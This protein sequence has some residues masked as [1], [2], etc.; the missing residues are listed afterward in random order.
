MLMGYSTKSYDES[1]QSAARS[2]RL[3]PVPSVDRP[4]SPEPMV[5]DR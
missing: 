3:P 1:L 2:F 5:A 4:T